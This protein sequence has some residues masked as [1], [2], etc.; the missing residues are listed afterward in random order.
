[1]SSVWDLSC[2]HG[3]QMSPSDL[4]DRPDYR[5]PSGGGGPITLCPQFKNWQYLP[6][7]DQFVHIN[8]NAHSLDFGGYGL[9]PPLVRCTRHPTRTVIRGSA[10]YRT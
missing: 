8:L 2:V 9:L 1:M 5:G 3:P 7:V 6:R 4:S 10:T